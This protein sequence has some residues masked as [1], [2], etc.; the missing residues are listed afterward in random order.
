MK[1][2]DN[3]CFGNQRRHQS[4]RMRTDKMGSTV[5]VG[6]R[7]HTIEGLGYQTQGP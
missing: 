6:G 4:P 2:I 7:G 3:K 5:E 1:G